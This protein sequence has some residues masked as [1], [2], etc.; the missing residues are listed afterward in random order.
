MNSLTALEPYI[1][2]F[3]NVNTSIFFDPYILTKFPIDL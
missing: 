2:S 1:E 3:D